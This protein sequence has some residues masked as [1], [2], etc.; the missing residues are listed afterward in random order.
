MRRLP[1]RKL[2]VAERIAVDPAPVCTPESRG[3]RTEKAVFSGVVQGFVARPGQRRVV[4][5]LG[6]LEWDDSCDYKAERSRQA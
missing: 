6:A 1:Q 4:D 5:L 2:P 3:E